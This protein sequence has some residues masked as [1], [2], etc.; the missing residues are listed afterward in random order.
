MYLFI[1]VNIYVYTFIGD[2]QHGMK[3][4]KKDLIDALKVSIILQF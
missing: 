4:L 1:C 3:S 2:T